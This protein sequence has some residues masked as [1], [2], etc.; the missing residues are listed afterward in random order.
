MQT[1]KCH[2]S[3]VPSRSP[4]YFEYFDFSANSSSTTSNLFPLELAACTT[5][6]RPSSRKESIHRI[7]VVDVVQNLVA[8]LLFRVV[9]LAIRKRMQLP[10]IQG[11]HLSLTKILLIT[12]ELQRQRPH[13][14]RLEIFKL[15]DDSAT[16]KFPFQ[17]G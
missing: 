8:L 3:S 11:C 7:F 10:S 5:A 6:S 13:T 4:K 9:E 14:M 16:L 17:R 2:Q 1:Q 12:S 15:F